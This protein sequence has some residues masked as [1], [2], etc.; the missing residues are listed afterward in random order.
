MEESH[1]RVKAKPSKRG[2][3]YEKDCDFVGCA[4][5]IGAKRVLKTKLV[6]GKHDLYSIKTGLRV[7]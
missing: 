5:F 2:T 4:E 1:S 6:S 7:V 3:N